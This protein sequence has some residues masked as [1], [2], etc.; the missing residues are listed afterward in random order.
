VLLSIKI[1]IQKQT[2]KEAKEK[3]Q[4]TIK[5]NR[6]YSKHYLDSHPSQGL[7]VLKAIANYYNCGA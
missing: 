1:Q 5:Q 7:L 3:K 6:S 2:K 4:K